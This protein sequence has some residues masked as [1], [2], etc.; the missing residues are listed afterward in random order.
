MF[1]FETYAIF[2]FGIKTKEKKGL[3]E[4]KNFYENSK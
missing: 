3:F 1:S 4:E 2:N